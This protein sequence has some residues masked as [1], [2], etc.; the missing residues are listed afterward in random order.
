MFVSYYFI[1][2]CFLTVIDGKFLITKSILF[3]YKCV[4]IYIFY[5]IYSF[6]SPEGKKLIH[7][8]VL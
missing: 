8:P 6:I 5:V 7:Y 3:I 4:I 2:T 1:I